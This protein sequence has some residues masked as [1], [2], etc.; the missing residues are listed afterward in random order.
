MVSSTDC[1]IMI[2]INR[3]TSLKASNLTA[4]I[5]QSMVC[6]YGSVPTRTNVAENPQIAKA[7]ITTGEVLSANASPASV[8]N[9]SK[10]N[11]RMF[12]V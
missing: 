8:G 6:L 3:I 1:L 7:M 5:I 12:K 9:E 11:T 2:M 10:S 4:S